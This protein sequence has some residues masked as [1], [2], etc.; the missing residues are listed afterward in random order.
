MEQHGAA[1]PRD[2]DRRD[3]RHTML[4]RPIVSFDIETIPDPDLGRRL[5]GFEGTD[6]E[7]VHQM[8]ARRREETGGST[9]Y[10][11]QP[12][13]RIVCVCATVLDPGR[14]AAWIRYL[15]GDLLDERSQIEGFFR[16]VTTELDAP[17]LVSW[18][19]AGFDLPILRYRGMLHGI[20]APGFYRADGGWKWNNYQGRYHDMHVDV[21]DVLAGFG[22]GP[23]V[24]LGTLSR[25]LS[26]PTKSFLERPI[27]DH[28]LDGGW[29][30]VV[31]YCKL[32]TVDTLL[33]FLLWAHHSGHLWRDDLPV[34]VDAVRQ[35]VS[36]QPHEGW[37]EIER[38]LAGWPPWAH[39]DDA[40]G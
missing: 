15:G 32:D 2:L 12:W 1:P 26:M 23:R 17:R 13:H 24:G 11:Q 36:E 39:R 16:L 4:D 5:L 22:A 30:A 10:P 40:T 25:V 7:V 38:G 19:G 37:R 35:A 9:E 29:E 27:Y 3:R 33:V 18:N 21:M 34:L 8:V 20:A 14:R 6:L 31:E 28:V